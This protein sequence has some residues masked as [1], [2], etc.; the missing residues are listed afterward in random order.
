LEF[1]IRYTE[2][3][4]IVGDDS[5]EEGTDADSAGEEVGRFRADS[6]EPFG[7]IV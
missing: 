2:S 7:S 5:I 4:T 3:A 1:G 6:D